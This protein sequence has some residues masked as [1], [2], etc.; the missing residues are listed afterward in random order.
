MSFC[1]GGCIIF[2]FC[3][4]I[5]LVSVDFVEI[6]ENIDGSKFNWDE[7]IFGF[8]SLDIKDCEVFFLCNIDLVIVKV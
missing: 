2:G 1:Y 8:L 4:N 3:W 5:M 7:Y 6:Y